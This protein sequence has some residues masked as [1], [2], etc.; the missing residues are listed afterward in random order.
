MRV[1]VIAC[2]LLMA[3]GAA[4]QEEPVEA[5]EAAVP[6]DAANAP[7]PGDPV[8]VPMPGDA[9]DIPM[10]GDAMD[11]P[12][13]GGAAAPTPGSTAPGSALLSGALELLAKSELRGYVEDTVNLEYRLAADE[14]FPL[15]IFRT[16]LALS[17]R[18]HGNVDYAISL[19]GT[20]H[21]GASEIP[22]A[23]YLPDDLQAD[24][25]PAQA[26]LGLPGTAD[27]LIFTLE[28]RLYL[29]EAF[30]TLRTDYIRIRAGRHKY[31]SGTGFAYNPID[32]LNVKNPI[33]PTYELDGLD[34][35]LA[36]VPLPLESELHGFVRFGESFERVDFVGKLKTVIAGW[37]IG[38]QYTFAN[39]ERIDWQAINTPEG[40]GMLALGLPI[41][42]FTRNF[43]WHL[44][45]AEL[46]GELFGVGIHAEGGYAVVQEP[47]EVGTLTDAGE[48]HERFL[49]G[50]DYTFD[51]QLYVMVE[52]LRLGQ[53]RAHASE[54]TLNDRM[55]SFSGE[56][57]AIDRDTLFI[58]ASYPI[59]DL[60]ELSVYGI[61][62]M[63]D[64]SAL[65]NPWLLVDLYPGLKL[66]VSAFF[67]IG[68]EAGQNGKM[69]FGG[70]ARLRLSI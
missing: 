45:A 64:P 11:I 59:A 10:P 18:P 61:V 23:P 2:C 35:I 47:E 17:G 43:Q 50:V 49:V 27:L 21:S 70:F 14:A 15:N 40:I 8:D 29:Q 9:M 42:T 69:G 26:T 7:L 66:S 44:I 16:R 51:F 25:V 3:T 38:L 34:G 22:V 65:V 19:V 58:G 52:Y 36:V 28:D 1:T 41:D 4:A 5:S 33:D 30:L 57:L 6:G 46:S 53:G 48:D 24:L 20:L 39:R 13:P 60:V 55:A 68:D 63:N 62:G 56:I 67:P 32:L 54:I 37:D 31:Y 12:M